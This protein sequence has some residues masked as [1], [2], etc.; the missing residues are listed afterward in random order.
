MLG[1]SSGTPT[2]VP[3]MEPLTGDGMAAGLAR[4]L[5][6]SW[7]DP[8]WWEAGEMSEVA[9]VAGEGEMSEVALVGAQ[10]AV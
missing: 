4:R 7:L 5:T 6:A 8:A 3:K 10:A 1:R 9:L 2:M